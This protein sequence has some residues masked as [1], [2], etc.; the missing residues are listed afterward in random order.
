MIVDSYSYYVAAIPAKG[1]DDCAEK[2][3]IQKKKTELYI[4]LK[5]KTIKMDNIFKLI[6]IKNKQKKD[7]DIKIEPTAPY[8][9]N[10]NGVVEKVI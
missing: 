4:R 2:L 10:Q 9:L 6:E 5:L 3:R 1:K 8:T 7:T